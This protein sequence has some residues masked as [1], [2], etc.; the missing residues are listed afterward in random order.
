[1]TFRDRLQMQFEKVKQAV[2]VVF[3]FSDDFDGDD[4][5]DDAVIYV[6][7]VYDHID[8]DLRSY[9]DDR[10]DDESNLDVCDPFIIVDDT[11]HVIIIL[12]FPLVK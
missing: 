10:N 11:C 9:I 12:Y 1:M 2:V 6:N 7:I 5:D 8:Y 4:N 3:V